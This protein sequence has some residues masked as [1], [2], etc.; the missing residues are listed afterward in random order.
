MTDYDNEPRPAQKSRQQTAY[1]LIGVAVFI[2]LANTGLI[3][4]LGIDD[5]IGWIFS[6]V[7]N[8][9]PAAFIAVG[10]LWLHRSEEGQ[11]PIMGWF[12]VIFGSILLISQFDLFG[13]SFGNMFFPMILVIVALSLINPDKILPGKLWPGTSDM[14]EDGSSIRLFAFM[15]GG[16]M[17]YTTKTL[18][19][20]EV[21]AFMGGYQID[22]T[23]ADMEGDVMVINV[24]YIMGG[25]EIRVPCHWSVEQNAI[26]IMGGFSNTTTCLAEKLD[27]PRKKLIV[28]G[29][30]FMGGGEIKN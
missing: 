13:L 23:E 16:E 9:I 25:A 28:K 29:F 11:K 1:I 27:M 17:R 24:A 15:G 18:T 7:F 20:A 10:A 30:A 2:V 3:G 6:T 14:G 5:L 22:L 8:L 12:M 4:A 19:G 26:A 21:G